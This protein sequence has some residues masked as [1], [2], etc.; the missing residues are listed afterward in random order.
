MGKHD[1]QMVTLTSKAV[2]RQARNFSNI[3]IRPILRLSLYIIYAA[4]PMVHYALLAVDP[5]IR[6]SVYSYVH[7]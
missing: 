2:G 7:T 4:P 6:P 3:L 1:T 5:S